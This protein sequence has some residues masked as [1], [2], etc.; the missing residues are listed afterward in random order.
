MPIAPLIGKGVGPGGS[1]AYIVR[2]GLSAAAVVGPA[3]VGLFDWPLLWGP[4][5]GAGP[6]T[7]VTLMARTR[8]SL[9]LGAL[10]DENVIL[11]ARTHQNVQLGPLI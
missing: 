11:T 7:A 8:D 10:T 4:L 9:T 6:I 2:K 3:T 5:T 1:P